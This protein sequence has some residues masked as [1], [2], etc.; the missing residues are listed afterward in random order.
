MATLV[1]K[2]FKIYSNFFPISPKFKFL[3]KIVT[4]AYTEGSV[5]MIG[6]NQKQNLLNQNF[7]SF[8]INTININ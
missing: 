4:A 6:K 2:N 5:N 3:N 8:I 7:K 1:L